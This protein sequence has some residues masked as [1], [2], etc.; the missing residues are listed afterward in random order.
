MLGWQPGWRT[1]AC[2]SGVP[3]KTKVSGSN[4][5][6][7]G[8]R[9]TEG[10]ESWGAEGSPGREGKLTEGRETEGKEKEEPPL[11]SFP[12]SGTGEALEVLLPW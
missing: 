7:A 1:A 9:D 12:C 3:G 11:D 2:S 4:E 8:D 5:P 6:L 10:G